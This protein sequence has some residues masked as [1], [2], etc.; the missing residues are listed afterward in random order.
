M[1][2]IIKDTECD[3]AL[4]L[5]VHLDKEL[6]GAEGTRVYTMCLYAY[7]NNGICKQTNKHI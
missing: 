4:E 5:T 7:K 3:H 6:D 2:C 1:R